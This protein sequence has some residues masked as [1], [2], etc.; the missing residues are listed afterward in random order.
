MLLID[1]R[2]GGEIDNSPRFFLF[3]NRFDERTIANIAVHKTLLIAGE[4]GSIFEIA[5]ISQLIQIDD[6]ITMD[7]RIAGCTKLL[8]INPQ[9]PV[10]KMV[11]MIFPFSNQFQISY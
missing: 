2:F 5:G 11:F 8:P 1:V 10:T 4:I 3:E 9:P 6:P 7:Q